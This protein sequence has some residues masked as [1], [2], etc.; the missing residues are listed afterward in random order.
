M[1]RGVVVAVIFLLF[2]AISSYGKDLSLNVRSVKTK[3][4]EESKTDIVIEF[5]FDIE[6]ENLS[7]SNIILFWD[8]TDLMPGSKNRVEQSRPEIFLLGMS[9]YSLGEDSSENTL[10]LVRARPSNYVS[11]EVEELKR[12]LNSSSPPSDLTFVLNR[13]ES[14]SY[15]MK[16]MFRFGKQKDK[17]SINVTWQELV[18]LSPVY[19]RIAL[20]MFPHIINT[21]PNSNKYFPL[22]KKLRAKWK[23][24]GYLWLDDITSEPIQVD[25]RSLAVNR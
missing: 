23:E 15:Q 1:V 18:G 20:E 11:P 8:K 4:V 3:L 6:F 22:G 17:Y 21:E 16:E 10:Y 5:S 12:R 14:I 9:L 2:V 25:F 7:E 13:G 24:F 19:M